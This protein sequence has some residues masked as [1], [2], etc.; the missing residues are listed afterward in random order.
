MSGILDLALLGGTLLCGFGTALALQ[1][2]TLGLIF[3]VIKS[4]QV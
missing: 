1:R 3:K 4:R 2:A